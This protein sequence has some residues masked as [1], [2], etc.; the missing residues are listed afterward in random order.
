MFITEIGEYTYLNS[1]GDKI[2]FGVVLLVQKIYKGLVCD[3]EQ[4]Q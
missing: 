2:L 4:K 1:D 3:F